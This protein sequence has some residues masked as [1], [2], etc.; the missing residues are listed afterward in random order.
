MTLCFK[1]VPSLAP[2][3]TNSS[4]SFSLLASGS[5]T[6]LFDE[7][8]LVS[9]EK[10]PPLDVTA[11]AWFFSLS[12]AVDVSCFYGSIAGEF[13]TFGVLSGGR[14]AVGGLSLDRTCWNE[15]CGL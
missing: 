4:S 11:A 10:N 2:I 12:F 15:I 9:I 13:S 3:L 8:K 14:A 5:S 7:K 1:I 6:P